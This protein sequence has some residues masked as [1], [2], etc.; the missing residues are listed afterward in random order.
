MSSKPDCRF[1]LHDKT[2]ERFATSRTSFCSEFPADVEYTK[3]ATIK[4]AS[5]FSLVW[6]IIKT[7]ELGLELL[8]EDGQTFEIWASGDVQDWISIGTITIENGTAIFIDEDA[9]N[10]GN[11]FCKGVQ[12]IP[13]Q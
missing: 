8:A 3:P 13:A 10:F 5:R 7:G 6:N 12:K 4:T 9:A 11:R 2:L 1:S